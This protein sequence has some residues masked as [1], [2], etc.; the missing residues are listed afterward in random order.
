MHVGILNAI[1]DFKY[2]FLSLGPRHWGLQDLACAE[3]MTHQN[4]PRSEMWEL[5]RKTK[6]NVMTNLLFINTEHAKRIK[7]IKNWD[8]NEAFSHID[9]LMLPQIK[10]RPFESAIN[11]C[12]MLVKRDPWNII[13]YWFEPDKE[14]IYYD[15]E[16]D[17]PE[18]INGILSN[19]EDYES[20]IENAFKKAINNYTTDHFMEI[21]KRECI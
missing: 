1:K 13:E 11:R 17:L 5:I 6:I 9:E 2:N 12:L 7:K 19:W 4:A 10:T 20:I 8:K 16:E 18:I 15:N 21:V 14:F 3:L